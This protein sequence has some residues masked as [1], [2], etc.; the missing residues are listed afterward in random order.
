[1]STRP[2]F[3][4]GAPSVF[5]VYDVAMCLWALQRNAYNTHLYTGDNSLYVDDNSLYTGE[6]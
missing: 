1:M 2:Q 5:V 4:F 6:R 3:V